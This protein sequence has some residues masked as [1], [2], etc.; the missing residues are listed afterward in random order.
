MGRN[1]KNNRS[2][3]PKN[4]DDEYDLKASL[5]KVRQKGYI[6]NSTTHNDKNN[7]RTENSIISSDQI[8]VSDYT[9]SFMQINDTINSRYDKLND[10][11]SRYKESN[12]S[13]HY[14]LD[15][16]LRC[17]I[18]KEIDTVRKELSNK[19]DY[20]WF[21]AAVGVL[22]TIGSLFYLLSYNDALRNIDENKNKLINIEKESYKNQADTINT[23]RNK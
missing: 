18:R 9:H 8:Y 5:R 2:S 12:N 7:E 17:E 15:K 4:L 23:S 22:I 20:K 19:L 13:E 6:P 3:S 16:E 1:N 14:L 11:L 10:D 21:S